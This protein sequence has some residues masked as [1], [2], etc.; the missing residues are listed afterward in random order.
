M[1]TPMDAFVAPALEVDGL[2]KAYRGKRALDGVS[3]VLPKGGLTVILG[4]AGAGKTTALRLIAG[5]EQADS[6]LI[7]LGGRDCAGLEPRDRNLAMIFDNL[8]LYPDKTGFENIANPLRISGM[9]KAEIE[10]RVQD[11]A[12][13]L[14]IAHILGRTP[15]TMSGGERQRV[16]LG[17]A[18]VRKPDLFL[19]DEPLSSLDAMLRIELRAELR[20]L[21]RQLGGTFLLA[22]P[23]FTEAMAIADTV[24]ML[25]EGRI[26]Q[27]ADPQTLY[28]EPVDREVAKFVGAPE[29]NLVPAR[30]SPEEGGR[31]YM[32]GMACSAPVAL[33]RVTKGDFT[34]E[35]G[36]RPEFIRLSAPGEGD[37]PGRIADIEPL[38]INA[39]VTVATQGAE[40]RLVT[41]ASTI[42]HLAAG[43]AAGLSIDTE[44]MLAFD[45]ETGAR[46]S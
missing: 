27:I 38:G 8:A 21:Q 41:A 28:D 23:D 26:I 39:S 29:I 18:L 36:L 32:A 34:F 43:D 24:V 4:A 1:V 40:L 45:L 11:V 35:A 13:T 12:A 31:V 14:K 10:T 5:L 3:F 33:R 7:L 17:R 37:L 15:K 46:L 19:L 20:R 42:A 16:A 44:H 2:S 22:T 25:R 9:G 30:Y 6:G